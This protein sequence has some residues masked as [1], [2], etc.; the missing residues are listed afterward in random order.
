VSG[1]KIYLEPRAVCVEESG[2]S[3]LLS[4]DESITLRTLSADSTG[5]YIEPPVDTFVQYI[6]MDCG[7]LYAKIPDDEECEVCGSDEFDYIDLMPDW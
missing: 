1:N 6:C 3:V 5:I 2:I 7:T 4:S